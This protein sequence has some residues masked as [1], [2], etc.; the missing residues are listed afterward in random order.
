MQRRTTQRSSAKQ[1][2]PAN[3]SFAVRGGAD[4][5]DDKNKSRRVRPTLLISAVIIFAFAVFCTHSFLTPSHKIEL[6]QA[7]HRVEDSLQNR[8]SAA[9]L[10]EEPQTRTKNDQKS[11]RQIETKK[12]E[13]E[14]PQQE[15]PHPEE[16][17]DPP[18]NANRN[19]ASSD[20]ATARMEAQPSGWMDGE[21]ALK[22]KLR[23]LYDIQKKGQSLGVPVLTRYMGEDIPAFVG[24]PD[25]TM[26][27]EEWK[28][29]V[30]AK[31]EEMTKEEEVWRKKMAL[32]IETKDR[33][34]GI[35][36]P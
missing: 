20:A 3:S 29:L 12:D 22:K 7:E 15:E 14:K 31:Y 17:A 8:Q 6:V 27:E 30:D 19:R 4:E 25:S 32:L 35:T 1:H 16:H 36:T 21:K 26:N 24:T 2:S 28:K 13:Q 10:K 34:I 11:R 23:V 5:F 9:R 33:D 18:D